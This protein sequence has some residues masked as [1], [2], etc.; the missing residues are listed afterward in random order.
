[1][2][3]QMSKR[4]ARWAWFLLPV[5]IVLVFNKLIV[6]SLTLW[7]QIYGQIPAV[8][9]FILPFLSVIPPLLL[10]SIWYMRSSCDLNPKQSI[11]SRNMLMSDI[12]LGAAAGFFCLLVFIGSLKML[13]SY[14]LGSPNFSSLSLAHHLFFSTV[15]AL[16]PGISEELYFR[17]FLMARFRDL[18]PSLLIILT[19][20][21]FSLWHVLSPSYLLHTFVIGVILGL[22]VYRTQ[23]ILPAVIAHSLANAAAGVLIIKGWV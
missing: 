11:Y 19:S 4:Y 7:H 12:R 3:T 1:M 15:G 17:G 13:R 9:F 2:D 18:P 22:T 5:V 21:S 16:I 20:I 10:L 8:I 6:Y 23:R 14:G